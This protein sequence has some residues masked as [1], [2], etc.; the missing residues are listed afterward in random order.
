VSALEIERHIERC[1]D[2]S[3]LNQALEQLHADL[4]RNLSPLEIPSALR[5]RIDKALH[6]E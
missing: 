4:R 6:A 2:C 1:A 5:A 3:S